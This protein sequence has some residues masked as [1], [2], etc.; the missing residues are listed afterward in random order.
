MN[1]A[2]CAIL[3]W[4]LIRVMTGG[5]EVAPKR[6]HVHWRGPNN[7]AFVRTLRGSLGVSAVMYELAAYIAAEPP[8]ASW[9][10]TPDALR[11]TLTISDSYCKDFF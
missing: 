2:I 8:R 5:H 11:N 7:L 9:T 6:V 1:S 3:A 10:C 4:G